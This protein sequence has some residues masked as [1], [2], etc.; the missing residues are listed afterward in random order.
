MQPKSF[1]ILF[2]H[3]ILF[4][5]FLSGHSFASTV[6]IMATV[7][8]NAST[9]GDYIL[10]QLS[11]KGTRNEPLLPE[12]PAFKVQSRGTSSQVQIINGEMSSSVTHSYILYPLQTGSFTIGPFTVMNKG[13][14][15]QS[16]SI[17]ISIGKSSQ[18]K[19]DHSRDVFISAE[20]DNAH[21]YLHEEIIY[22]FKFYRR[23]RVANVLLSNN[24]SFE[25]FITEDI[26]KEKEYQEVINGQ[27][28]H[29]TEISKALFPVRTGVLQISPSTLQCDV[30]VKKRRQG[31]GFFGDSLFDDPFFGRSQAV[32]KSMSTKAL[33]VMVKPLPE[34][35]RPLGFKNLVG[36]FK[37]TSKINRS[38]LKAGDSLTLTLTLAGTGNLK[39]TRTIEIKGLHDFKV[40]DDKPVFKSVISDGKTG[41]KLTVKK[42]LVPLT[43]G[44]LTIPAITVDFF[45]P[46]DG[47]YKKLKTGPYKLDI[48][49]S[50]EKDTFNAIESVNSKTGAKQKI[51]ILGHD[52]LP[53]LTSLDAVSSNKIRPASLLNIICFL[54]PITGF[55]FAFSFGRIKQRNEQDSGFVRSKNAVKNFKRMLPEIK[56]SISR[57]NKTFHTASSKALK[58]FIGDKLNVAGSAMT[59]E[60][61]E[62]GLLIA[63]A[64]EHDISEVIRIIS[65]FESGQFG[66]KNYSSNEKQAVFNSMRKLVKTLN[67]NL[68]C[69]GNNKKGNQ[70]PIV[71]FF[72]LL[73]ALSS[74]FYAAAQA[75][76][77]TTDIPHL[78]LMANQAYLASDYQ[79]AV[80]YYEQIIACGTVNGKIY[81]NLGNAYVK[82]GKTGKALLNYR[83]A[84]ILIPRN[85]DLQ[86]NLHYTRGLLIDQIDCREI[87]SFLKGFCFWYSKLNINELVIV[88]LIANLIFW[89]ILTGRLLLKRNDL[90]FVLYAFM[91][92]TLILGTSTLVKTYNHYFKH[93]GIV[94]SRE[95]QI[96]SGSSINDTVLFKLHEGTE[97]EWLDEGEGW[98][99]I[100]LCDGK[101]GWVRSETVSIIK[102]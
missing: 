11:V 50:S 32:P 63:G 55:V 8:K 65:F 56:D 5:L 94:L 91:A 57:K 95:I 38:K 59:S 7:D 88:F 30:V 86:T 66:F 25:G 26:G 34:Q 53:I 12:M 39:T 42:A 20:V 67:K 98:V 100:R 96:R 82:N 78:F 70:L 46:N 36:D 60:E 24:P 52:I 75:K 51:K 93:N 99:K 54:L 41:G 14:E 13:N 58:T 92:I 85:E 28:Y 76:D 21:P 16:N 9:P 64:R 4:L 73:H 101:K 68:N 3:T 83:K 43:E 15:V 77:N 17:K 10:L 61:L 47:T 89:S 37:L 2:I 74:D 71:L 49:P 18:N 84:E 6:S 29:V 40:Y 35:G 44:N 97:F 23:V 90:T 80:D 79:N 81:Y 72:I 27:T 45:D 62:N 87:Y 1:F 48:L 31:R 69:R 22:S 19:W 102:L 33:S